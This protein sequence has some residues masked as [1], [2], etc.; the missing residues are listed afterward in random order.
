L[1]TVSEGDGPV[2]A[3]DNAVRKALLPMYKEIENFRLND[4]KVRILDSKSA[5]AA[6]VRVTIETTNGSKV[7]DTVGV[8]ENIIEASYMAILDSVNYGLLISSAKPCMK[9]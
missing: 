1:H 7:W 8:S 6:K 2:N 9:K 5:T 4:F 3:I